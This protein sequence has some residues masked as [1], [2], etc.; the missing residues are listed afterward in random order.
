[1]MLG[2]SRDEIDSSFP[3]Q[4]VSTGISF[5][6]V[7]LKTLKSLKRC[8]INKTKYFEIIEKAKAKS[9]LVF[10]PEAYKKTSD[11]GVRVFTEYYGIPEDPATG[12][13]NGCLAAYLCKHKYFGR[14]TVNVTVDQGY[15]IGRHSKLYL[16]AA[17]KDGKIH[18]YVGGMVFDIAQGTISI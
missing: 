6:I 5:I 8:R 1:T 17:L 4:E 9:I 10:S 11:L 16:K 13:G 15:E 14:N 18:V 3:I 7:P 2:I 12:S